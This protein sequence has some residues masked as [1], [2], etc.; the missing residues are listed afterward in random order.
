MYNLSKT[1]HIELIIDETVIYSISRSE[2]VR[3]R[4]LYIQIS[5][6][7]NGNQK[8]QIELNKTKGVIMS[9]TGE[10]NL[11][12]R[13]TIHGYRQVSNDSALCFEILLNQNFPST[14]KNHRSSPPSKL[15]CTLESI[16]K[17]DAENDTS[18]TSLLCKILRI[19]F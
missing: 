12:A 14:Y 13:N 11:L 15:R 18:M 19:R 9:F 10:R 16:S 7:M 1:Y 2:F 17:Q 4:R 6:I 3:C 5:A 8:W